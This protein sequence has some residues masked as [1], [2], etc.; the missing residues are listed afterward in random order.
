M[1]DYTA[2]LIHEDRMA[3]F[4]SE[5]DAFRLASEAKRGRARQPRTS[6]IRSLA[7]AVARAGAGLAAVF[8]SWASH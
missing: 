2:R 6:R 7:S 5:A 4:N 8:A 1:H 3:Q